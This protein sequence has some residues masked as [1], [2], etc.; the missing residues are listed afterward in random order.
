[1][2]WAFILGAALGLVQALFSMP[3]DNAHHRPNPSSQLDLRWMVETA[4]LQLRA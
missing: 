3:V 4:D 1:M 2:T